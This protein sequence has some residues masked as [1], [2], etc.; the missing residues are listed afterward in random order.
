[1][2]SR[3]QYRLDLDRAQLGGEDPLEPNPATAAAYGDALT[4]LAIDFPEL[5]PATLIAFI[6]FHGHLPD[7]GGNLRSFLVFAADRR[8]A[9]AGAT[10]V[11]FACEPG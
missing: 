11:L 9:P 4:G 6:R 7:V 2:S 5:V 8:S 10:T 3:K 1:M